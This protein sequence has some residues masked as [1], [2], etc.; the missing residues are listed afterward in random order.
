[1][2]KQKLNRQ[3]RVTFARATPNEFF[4]VG[5]NA[6]VVTKLRVKFGVLKTLTENPNTCEFTI[7]NMRKESRAAVQQNPLFV[8]LEAGYGSELATIFEGDLVLAYSVHNGTD[9][10]TRV[11]VAEGDRAF[12]HS[13]VS[14]S[15]AAGASAKT[16]IAEV[17]KS[18]GLRM[19]TSI[20]DAKALAGQFVSGVTLHGPSRDQMTKILKPR[21]FDW[22]IQNNELQILAKNGVRPD[23]AIVISSKTGMVGVP[24]L[25]TPKEPG[26]PVTLKTKTLLDT[27][28]VPGG[29]VQMEAEEVK[30]LF[31]VDKVSF[32]GDTRGQ[33]FFSEVEGSML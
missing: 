7:Y 16:A 6:L 27:A 33:E 19:P 28:I 11:Q 24:E 32:V 2:A 4:T 17:A 31:R 18:M 10:E 25:G 5:A 1:M 22:S 30:G 13:R 15:F 20:A 3:V 14:K 12:R 9:W 29:R 23:Q 8:R 21:G 26:D